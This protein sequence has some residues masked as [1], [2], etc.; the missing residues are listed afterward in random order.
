MTELT[1]EFVGKFIEQNKIRK[2]IEVEEKTL[3][4]RQKVLVEYKGGAEQEVFPLEV[5]REI[6]SKDKYDLTELRE[7]RVIPIIKNM[8]ILLTEAELK[9]E[10]IEHI[11][12]IRL[13]SA[14]NDSLDRAS[15]KLWGKE[16]FNITLKDADDILRPKDIDK[17]DS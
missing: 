5:L 8:L 4:G 12:G 15:D 16:S 9:K 6:A 1:K 2:V 17:K 11:I 3:L 10:D 7:K 14:I 13:K